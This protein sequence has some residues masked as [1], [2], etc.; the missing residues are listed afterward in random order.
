VEGVTARRRAVIATAATVILT[1]SACSS[2]TGSSDSSKSS[3]TSRDTATTTGSAPASE[4]V[5]AWRPSLGNDYGPA[6]QAFL[7]AVQGARVVEVQ[8]ATQRLLAGN[9]ALRAAINDAGAPPGSDREAAT[10]L[11]RALARE[12]KLAEEIQ[13]VCTGTNPRCEE[14]VSSYVDNNSEQVIP[15]LVALRA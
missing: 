13:R 15:A 11:K 5:A 7:A 2:S 1:L 12:H 8:A 4:W 9:T 14:V 3:D 6:Q 10:R